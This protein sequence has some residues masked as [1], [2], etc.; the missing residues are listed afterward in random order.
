MKAHEAVLSVRKQQEMTAPLRQ[1]MPLLW[2][3]CKE[4]KFAPS[5]VIS[6]VV[7]SRDSVGQ[8]VL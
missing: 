8:L 7:V 2:W 1:R 5:E 6:D 4:R 3:Q